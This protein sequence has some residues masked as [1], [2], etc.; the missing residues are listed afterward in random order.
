MRSRLF[1][2]QVLA[3]SS[4]DPKLSQADLLS[5]LLPM[6]AGS[7]D[8]TRCFIIKGLGL[9]LQ[10]VGHYL[11]I[12]FNGG[13]RSILELLGSV[14]FVHTS[15]VFRAEWISIVKKHSPVGMGTSNGSSHG[16][17]EDEGN[18]KPATAPPSDL[19]SDFPLWPREALAESFTSTSLIVDEFLETLLKDTSLIQY[20]LEVLSLFGSQTVDTNISLTAVEVMWK[21][22]D[23]AMRSA[24]TTKQ[25][26]FNPL[27]ES[28]M[29]VMEGRLH[30]LALDS[31]PEIRH[32]A[33]NT[34]FVALSANAKA[35]SPLRWTSSFT[36]NI[37]PLFEK[38]NARSQLAMRYKSFFH[39]FDTAS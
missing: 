37:V 16:T 18:E 28:I 3:E 14:P 33:I 26:E 15:N 24:T 10:S 11:D 32:C 30:Q 38:I 4:Q 12:G 13:W 17:D 7:V 27:A 34:L 22:A 5:C 25:E 36:N 35:F 39:K 19:I 21:V 1:F 23:S 20:L 29:V 8:D 9:F 2:Q 31:R 6:S